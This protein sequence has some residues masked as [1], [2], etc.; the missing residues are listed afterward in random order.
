[1]A[2]KEHTEKLM[3]GNGDKITDSQVS[4]GRSSMRKSEG[5]RSTELNTNGLKSSHG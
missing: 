2:A 1:M 3:G 5:S 4:A